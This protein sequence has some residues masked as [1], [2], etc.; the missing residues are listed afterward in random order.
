MLFAYP[1]PSDT[2]N[3]FHTCIETILQEVH[4]RAQSNTPLPAWPNIIPDQHKADLRRKSSLEGAVFAYD[5]ALRRLSQKNRDRVYKAFQ[6]QNEIASLLANK[7]SCELINS[8]PA[9]IRKPISDLFDDAF[10]LLTAL[11]VRQSHY[12]TI[13]KGI[14]A[15][16]C[17]F[18]GFEPL[19][20]PGGPSEPMDHYLASSIYPF[21]GVNL[22]NLPFMGNKCNSRYKH[23]DDIILL[24]GARRTACYP[25]NAPALKLDLTKS[26]PFKGKDGELPAWVIEFSPHSPEVDTWIEVFHIR[27]RYI[28][29]VLDLSFKRWIGTFQSVCKRK[30]ADLSDTSTLLHHLNEH[31]LDHEVDGFGNQAFIRA[32]MFRMLHSHCSNGHSDLISLLQKLTS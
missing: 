1:E 9:T 4:A 18:C 19:D 23:D 5:K 21:A 15:H 22:K 32:A 28:R 24:A 7:S 8:L 11:K 13:C 27:E 2:Q 31:V 17:P 10:R 3:W 29:D 30:N 26:E 12:A 6:E 20:G 14:P 16:V 25:Y